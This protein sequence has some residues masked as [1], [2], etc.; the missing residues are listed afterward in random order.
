MDFPF[1]FH[2]LSKKII[3]A[4]LLF[5]FFIRSLG[6]HE[7][8]FPTLPVWQRVSLKV[9]T[10][11]CPTIWSQKICI[12]EAHGNLLFTPFH[13][14]HLVVWYIAYSTTTLVVSAC[15]LC[16]YDLQQCDHYT[17]DQGYLWL[18]IM[19]PMESVKQ[20]F[21]WQ[22][23]SLLLFWKLRVNLLKVGWGKALGKWGNET[24]AASWCDR[25]FLAKEMTT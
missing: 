10:I 20:A 25:R 4:S 7:I 16:M 5:P 18:A 24:F 1:C 22:N 11:C 15:D 9:D 17:C 19:G 2:W 6:L 21:M 14:L 23:T 8:T 12:K 3:T 13:S